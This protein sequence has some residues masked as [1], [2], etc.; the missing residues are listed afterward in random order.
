MSKKLEGNG[1]WESSRMLLPE[2]R[3]QHNERQTPHLNKANFPTTEE[4]E[5][6]RQYVLLPIMITIVENNRK[7]IEMSQ[8]PLKKLYVTASEVLMNHIH[9]DLVSIQKTLRERNIKVFE[10]EK[11]DSALHYR[12]V[13]RGYE[14]K[15]AMMRDLVRAEISIGMSKYISKIFK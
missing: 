6:I 3:K 4:L 11:V 15:F 2:H 13:C 9:A 8:Y 7:T 5:K 14:D 1:R 12:Y 10:E